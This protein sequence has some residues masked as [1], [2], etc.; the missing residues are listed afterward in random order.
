MNHSE[1][2][3]KFWLVYPKKRA[4]GN[5]RKWFGRHKPTIELLNRMLI[6]IEAQ[7]KSKDWTKDGGQWIPYPA[8]W[9]NAEMWDDAEIVDVG[10]PKD[11]FK[12]FCFCGR[13]SVLSVGSQHFCGRKHR[14]EKMGW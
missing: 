13:E 11:K 8:S 5:A 4:K 9:L 3:E 14:I 12:R 10:K 7:K 6:T 2:F 1:Q